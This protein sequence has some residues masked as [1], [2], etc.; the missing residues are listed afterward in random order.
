MDIII[1]LHMAILHMLTRNAVS[2]KVNTS[3]I[4]TIIVIQCDLH[5]LH[6]TFLTCFQ[7]YF[8][9]LIISGFKLEGSGIMVLVVKLGEFYS[10]HKKN[11]EKGVGIMSCVEKF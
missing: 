5:L 6:G 2:P 9:T 4:P 7:K 8:K 11:D 10:N 3:L 1:L